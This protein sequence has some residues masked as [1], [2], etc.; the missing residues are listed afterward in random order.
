[1]MKRVCSSALVL[2]FACS[3]GTG[4][5][6][7]APPVQASSAVAPSDATSAAA[8]AVPELV[9]GVGIGSLRIGMT[10]PEL[11]ALGLAT[12]AGPMPGD[13]VVGPYEVTFD[14]DRV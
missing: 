3:C 12:K 14:G 10:R 2:L 1:M 7:V 4:G 9:S 8:Q 5:S 13:L 6:D 11:D